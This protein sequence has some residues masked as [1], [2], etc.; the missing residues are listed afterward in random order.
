MADKKMT[1]AEKKAAT[2]AA[3]LAEVD[4]KAA[5]RKRLVGAGA[6]LAAVALFV[7]GYAVG[8]ATNDDGRLVGSAVI[9]DDDRVERDSPFVS[10]R[11]RSL[12][13]RWL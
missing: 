5:E 4:R 13:P 3:A 9:A 7:G 10:L 8:N 6:A 11:P 12:R 1:A 2:E